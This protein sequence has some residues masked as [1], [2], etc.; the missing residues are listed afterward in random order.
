MFFQIP[1]VL[2][3]LAINDLKSALSQ[4]MYIGSVTS[5]KS[6][7]S[8]WQDEIRPGRLQILAKFTTW[9]NV[10]KSQRKIPG[11]PKSWP[12]LL[13]LSY[14]SVFLWVEN[15]GPDFSWYLIT[16]TYSFPQLLFL[17]ST[18]LFFPF[19]NPA[20]LWAHFFSEVFLSSHFLCP[21]HSLCP[22]SASFPCSFGCS[23]FLSFHIQ[24]SL[25][26]LIT[27]RTLL[28]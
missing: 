18:A 21:L 20:I 8:V 10:S 24:K 26:K 9:A 3:F 4:T 12:D 7:A 23:S 6:T 13:F 5:P 19:L 16:Q 22:F 15:H 25:I 1:D 11:D 14:V 17:L 2:Y 28:T 27:T